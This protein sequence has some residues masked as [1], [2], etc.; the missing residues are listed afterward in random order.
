MKILWADCE[1]GG[2]EPKT[3]ALL[4]LSAIIEIDGKVIDEIDLKMKPLKNKAVHKEALDKQCRTMETIELFDPPI[5]CFNKF[6]KFLQREPKS[7]SNRF[8]VAGYNVD[9]DLRFINQ[10]FRDISGGPYKFWDYLQFSPIDVLPDL[11]TMRH[12]GLI[13]TPDTKLESVCKFFGIELEAHDAMSDIRAT[14]TLTKRVYNQLFGGWEFLESAHDI[15][16]ELRD[17]DYFGK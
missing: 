1:T 2:T 17:K 16:T 15:V 10:W 14:R 13:K 5:E 11:R 8:I 12:V 6:Y 4:Q 3:D 9:F 7:K